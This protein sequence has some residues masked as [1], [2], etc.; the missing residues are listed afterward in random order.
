M[1]NANGIVFAVKNLNLEEI[2]G[3]K[4]IEVGAYD[5]NGSLRPIIESWKE[6]A[7]YVGV[8]IE[9]ANLYFSTQN[10]I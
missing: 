3:K 5:V 8:D 1:C 7:E 9:N 6:T 10:I 2:K 4:I